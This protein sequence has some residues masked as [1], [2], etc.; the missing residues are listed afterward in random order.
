MRKIVARVVV[1]KKLSVFE[2]EMP[3]L[4]NSLSSACEGNCSSEQNTEL[5]STILLDS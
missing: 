1:P 2:G 5:P 4:G 3:N